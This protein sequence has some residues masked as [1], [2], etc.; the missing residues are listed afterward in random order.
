MK[1]FHNQEN[2]YVKQIVLKV[3]D[4]NKSLVFYQEILGLE[5]LEKKVNKVLLT[6]D[7][8]TAMITLTSSGDII[9][10]LPNRTG[11]YH[12]AIL[13]PDRFQLGLFL[14]NMREKN[15]EITGGSDH[16]VSEAIYLKDPDDNGIEVYADL[17][18]SEWN[19]KNGQIEM[20]TESLDYEG[21]LN[22]A[23]NSE[24]DGMPKKA[25]IGH[26]HFQVSDLE[27]AKKFYVQG[28]GFDIIQRLGK[29]ALF[30]STGGYHHH[31][32]L[33]TWDIKGADTLPENS[34]G[35]EYYTLNFPDQKKRNES[36][37]NLKKMGYKVIEKDNG[38]FT[39]DP[40]GNVIKL[41][42]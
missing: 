11:L 33:N 34:A 24:W 40:A 23:A 37:E 41:V 6:A 12:F 15:Y 42:I 2:K 16:G 38:I 13:L 10:K 17:D 1:E 20:V 39:E 4:L 26:I 29:S 7:G 27:K 18:T 32:G 31:I 9:E 25:K 14:K 21:I 19:R 22:E 8:A 36:L 35:L 3:R 5:I 30:L 28:L